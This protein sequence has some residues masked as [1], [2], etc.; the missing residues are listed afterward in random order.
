[1]NDEEM[2]YRE[3]NEEDPFYM[4]DDMEDYEVEESSNRKKTPIRPKAPLHKSKARLLREQKK[5]EDMKRIEKVVMKFIK[6]FFL[7]LF[8][9]IVFSIL[10][11][12]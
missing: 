4:G 2:L 9:F 6:F 1:M 12:M 7:I 8:L 3:M 5:E 11:F 10:L